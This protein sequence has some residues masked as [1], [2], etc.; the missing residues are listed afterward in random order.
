MFLTIHGYYI[1]FD[2][3][4]PHR[5]PQGGTLFFSIILNCPNFFCWKEILLI[6]IESI[7]PNIKT[8]NDHDKLFYMTTCENECANKVSK[9]LN[10]IFSSHLSNLSTIWKRLNGSWWFNYIKV[11]SVKGRAPYKMYIIILCKCEYQFSI[12]Y[13]LNILCV[14]CEC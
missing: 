3:L 12:Y 1:T 10:L 7:V 5:P 4:K 2:I 14:M 8:L 6:Q 9:F 11:C 13:C